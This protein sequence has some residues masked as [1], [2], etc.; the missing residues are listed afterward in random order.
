MFLYLFAGCVYNNKANY[1]IYKHVCE[2]RFVSVFDVLQLT[3]RL[4]LRMYLYKE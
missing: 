4:P 2:S 1:F 3:L